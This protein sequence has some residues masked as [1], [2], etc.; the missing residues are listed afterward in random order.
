VSASIVAIHSPSMIE[1]LPRSR[2][3]PQIGREVVFGA[4]LHDGVW[5]DV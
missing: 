3:V 5:P 2:L 4:S 1:R